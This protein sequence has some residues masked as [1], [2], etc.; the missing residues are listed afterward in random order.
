LE[1]SRSPVCR[2]DEIVRHGTFGSAGQQLVHRRQSGVESAPGGVQVQAPDPRTLGA[3]K[4]L[5]LVEAIIQRRAHS[6][7][8]RA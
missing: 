8:V 2:F 5:G 7:S 1:G 4:L 6:A 3:D